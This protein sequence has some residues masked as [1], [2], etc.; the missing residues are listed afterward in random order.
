MPAATILVIDNLAY[1]KKATGIHTKLLSVF[2]RTVKAE[3]RHLYKLKPDQLLCLPTGDGAA[4]V[5]LHVDGFRRWS[6][7]SIVDLIVQLQTWAR[8]ESVSLRIG[9]HVGS[10]E[11]FKDINGNKNGCGSAVNVTQRN[12]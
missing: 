2:N 8:S 11:I 7:E 4:L 9:V 3:I 10:V 1:S 6:I 12:M 5:F